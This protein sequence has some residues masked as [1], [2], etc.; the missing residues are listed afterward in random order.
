M[1]IVC[2]KQYPQHVKIFIK[3]EEIGG[4]KWVKIRV[5]EHENAKKKRELMEIMSEK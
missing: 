3:N 5:R 2:C 4:G 1:Y